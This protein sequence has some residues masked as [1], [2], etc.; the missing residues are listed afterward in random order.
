MPVFAA[1]AKLPP[2]VTDFIQVNFRPGYGLGTLIFPFLFSREA[3]HV[4][5]PQ[6]RA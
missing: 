1:P 2:H 4:P 5:Q 3:R 6:R